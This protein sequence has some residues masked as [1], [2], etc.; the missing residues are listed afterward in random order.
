MRPP[1]SDAP[2]V[3][4]VLS[5]PEFPFPKSLSEPDMPSPVPGTY[6]VR[7][8]VAAYAVRLNVDKTAL[9]PMDYPLPV[10]REACIPGG[11][12]GH[13]T[14]AVNEPTNLPSAN[15]QTGPSDV[16]VVAVS[17][18]KAGAPQ[19]VPATP[20]PPAPRGVVPSHMASAV[21]SAERSLARTRLLVVGDSLSIALADVLERRLAKTPGL[22]FARLGKVSSGLA[23][24]D[25]FDWE[26]NM[27]EV[28]K[29]TIPDVVVIMIGA[30][31]NK[32]LRLPSGQGVA[33]GSRAWSDEYRRRAARLVEIARA[34][35]PAA[36]IVWVGAPVMGVAELAHDMPAVNRAL[37]EEMRR[38]PGCRFV[39]VWPVLAGPDG[40]YAEFLASGTRLRAKDGV[41]LAP[42]GAALLADACLTALAEPATGVMLSQFP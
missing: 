1:D 29:K 18:K 21:H 7:Q 23:R 40:G 25:F 30:N 33:F 41:H 8:P 42:A 38:I 31:D 11:D 39:D 12:P 26:R 16:S 22:A 28:A 32:S 9:H 13:R 3:T 6:A 37:A 20:V 19:N 4:A 35:N 34:S 5:T 17:H 2:M 10:R 14:Y 15:V 36:R 24:P 27:D